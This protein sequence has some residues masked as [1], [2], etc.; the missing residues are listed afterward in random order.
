MLHA[1]RL[2]LLGV[3]GL[4]V[5]AGGASADEPAGDMIVLTALPVTYSIAFALAAGT[6]VTVQ[7]V[8]DNGRRMNAQQNYFTLQAPKLAEQFAHAD[9]VVTI[10]KLWQDDPL[11]VAARA[12]NIRVIDIDA[13]KPYSDTLEGISVAFEPQTDAPWFA[14]DDEGERVPSMYFWLSASNVARAADIV[15]QDLMRLAPADAPKI[16]A[17]LAKYEREVLDIKREYEAKLA[18]LPDVTVYGLGSGLVYL[19]TDMSIFVDGYFL[20]QDINWTPDDVASFSRYLKE[21]GIKVVVH[22]WEPSEAI[23]GAI[24]SAGAKLVVL[25]LGDGGIVE[26]GHLVPNGYSRL[27]RSNLEA[28]YQALLAANR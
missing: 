22:Q 5:A 14:R 18:A 24:T 6:H 10:G 20:K 15:G 16:A 8:P 1:K 7:N 28:L 27:L 2:G 11:F 26:N 12:A 9:A 3:L 23:K 13:T 19:L 21:H 4:A 17:N 25:D